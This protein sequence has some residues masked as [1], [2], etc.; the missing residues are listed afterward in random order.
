MLMRTKYWALIVVLFVTMI[1]GSSHAQHGRDAAPPPA[2]T[3]PQ[4]AN[5]TAQSVNEQQ[6]MQE[7]R[8]LQGRVTIPDAK[9]AILEQ[10]QGREYQQFHERV[11]PWV[12]GILIIGMIVALAAFYFTRGRI[13]LEDSPQSGVKIKR[14]TA[15][16]RVTHWVTATSFIVLAITGLNYVFGKR[17]LMPLIGPDAFATWSQW[18]KYLHVTFAWP[19]MLGLLVMVVLW[20]KDNIPDRYDIEWLRQF[21]GFLSNRHPPARRFNAGQKL[22]FWSVVIG[23]LVLVGSGLVLLF[24]IWSVD[25]NGIQLAQYVHATAGAVM[26]AIII[27]HI[28]I[29]T[30]GMEGAYQ[31][32]GT[33]EV[34]L[35]WAKA[36]HRV[37]VEEEQAR[38]GSTP[39]VGRGAVPAE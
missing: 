26:T 7:L 15:I 1:G 16:E 14:F 4:G 11:L 2:V 12:A 20:I 33:G 13:T 23:G 34:D 35:A 21:G 18:A 9:A 25:I 3:S 37:W 39:Q 30:L 29:G 28:Y 6:L 31:A 24:P 32:M 19:F 38:I 36:H 27:A 22:V 8:R 17:L 10:P 5:P